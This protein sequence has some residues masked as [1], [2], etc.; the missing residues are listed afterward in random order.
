MRHADAV[1]ASDIVNLPRSQVGN[2]PQYL[3]ITLLG[4][5]WFR[6]KELIPSAALVSL[7][8]EF[9]V[10]E[11]S[12]RQAMRRLTA[13]QLLVYE[14]VGRNA[15]YGTRLN[16]GVAAAEQLRGALGFGSG[17]PE[18]DGKWTVVSY[19]VPEKDR[20]VRRWLRTGLRA[21]KFGLLN[22]AIWVTPHDRV[23]EAEELLDRLS[24][25]DAS[26]MR[27][28]LMPRTSGVSSYNDVFELETLRQDYLDFIARHEPTMAWASS[29]RVTPAEA[30]VLRTQLMNDWRSFRAKDPELPEVLLP[31]DWPRK[32]A[33][34]VFTSIYDSIGATAESRF[35]QILAGVA[36][37]LAKFVTHHAVGSLTAHN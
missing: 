15:F 16:S 3:L 10:S 2:E 32:H 22:D 6:R 34:A 35:R 36:P 8:K 20:D 5:Y 17:Y 31:F 30:L 27:A 37:E 23:A 24:V 12:A 19:S 18:W 25:T 1:T 7:L 29:G 4:D 21:Q 14:R 13:R 26:I 11:S 28:E 9:G 33:Y